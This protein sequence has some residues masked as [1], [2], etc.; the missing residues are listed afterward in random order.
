MK[1]SS[2]ASELDDTGNDPPSL[3]GP[4]QQVDEGAAL[5]GS[6]SQGSPLL[7]NDENLDLSRLN[8]SRTTPRI[9]KMEKKDAGRSPFSTPPRSGDRTLSGFLSSGPPSLFKT[10]IVDRV[11][12]QHSIREAASS[13]ST[14][15]V[16]DSNS[17][18]DSGPELDG[19]RE[20]HNGAVDPG[21]LSGLYPGC[22]TRCEYACHNKVSLEHHTTHTHFR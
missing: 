15:L 21:S 6:S 7:S 10:D 18:L 14:S 12:E 17:E 8:T 11:V 16:F 22:V 3:V 5:S 13:V 1:E 2:K 19:D 9:K 20:L 4:E